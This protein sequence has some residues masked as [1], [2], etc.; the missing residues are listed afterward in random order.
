MVNA[1]RF[2]SCE[3][4]G[5]CDDEYI[6]YP[7]AFEH[8]GGF[9]GPLL[10]RSEENPALV[11]RASVTTPGHE[12]DFLGKGLPQNEK[13]TAYPSVVVAQLLVSRICWL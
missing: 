6:R 2:N 4:V 7:H 10:S 13:K 12:A 3:F 9:L 1:G 5:T 8:R 11:G